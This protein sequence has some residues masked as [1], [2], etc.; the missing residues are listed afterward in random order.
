MMA[1]GRKRHRAGAASR[2]RRISHLAVIAGILL[3][4]GAIATWA[5]APT[6]SLEIK[7]SERLLLVRNGDHIERRYQIALGR[8][9]RGDKREAGDQRTPIGTYRIVEFHDNSRFHYFM[10]LNYPNVKDAFY[11][12]KRN[13]ISR[14]EFDRIIDA[15]KEGAAPPQNT[16]L[17]GRIGIHGIGEETGET[18]R[19]HD[20]LDWTEGCIAL[21]NGE[22]EELRHFVTLGTRVVI[23]E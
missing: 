13:A 11:G 10:L 20:A 19:I 4:T 23:S 18:L 6:Y 14:A 5:A 12:L 17:G 7:K 2:H 22:I 15:L 8:G 9:G 21:R 16:T 1:G 3:C